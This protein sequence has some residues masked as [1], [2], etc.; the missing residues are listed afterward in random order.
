MI[1]ILIPIYN[2]D[3]RILVREIVHQAE[4]LDIVYEIICIDN[5]SVFFR[6]KNLQISN[7]PYCSYEV[8]PTYIEQSAVRNRLAKAAK[9][10]YILFLDSD[11]KI[12]YYHFLL[13]YIQQ[14]PSSDLVSGGIHYLPWP[15]TPEYLLHWL[16]GIRREVKKSMKKDRFLSC[17]FMI[18]KSIF[19]KIQFN[20]DFTEYGHE[21]AVFGVELNKLKISRKHV[22]SPVTHNNLDHS[23]E[24]IV[25][26]R[27][28]ISDVAVYI[29]SN[30]VS[31]ANARGYGY[32]RGYLLLKM[33]NTSKIFAQLFMF[34][35][36][37]IEHNLRSRHP[38]LLLLDIYK[39][40]FL[41]HYVHKRKLIV[42]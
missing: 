17:N 3:A 32:L 33:T 14:I 15:P 30:S 39:V 25:N 28:S 13:N 24:F 16:F 6:D 29:K 4:Q 35:I 23:D 9:Y 18:R 11:L 26:L 31:F 10:D 20:E 22:F 38:L 21:N 27:K 5:H 36:R 42:H 7:Y 2:R 8:L 37:P 34:F 41:C 19:D 12:D 1:S 40:G